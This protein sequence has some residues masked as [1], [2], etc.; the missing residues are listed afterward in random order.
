MIEQLRQR[1]YQLAVK[2]LFDQ[3]VLAEL[4]KTLTGAEQQ[5][6]QIPNYSLPANGEQIT[7]DM[8][9][10]VDLNQEQIAHIAAQVAGGMANIQDIYPLATLQEGILYHHRLQQE[11]D[12]YISPVILSFAT[13]QEV[14]SF[15]QALQK[16]IDRH[17]IL[18]TS[19]AW[20]SLEEPV[21]VVWRSAVLPVTQITIDAQALADGDVLN[22]LTRRANGDYA[23]LDVTQA[24]LMA[25]Y[26]TED[27]V[28]NRWLLCLINHH[29]NSDHTTMELLV[30]EVFAHMAGREA[31]LPTPLPFRDFVATSRFNA[32][33]EQ[34]QAFFT[35]QFADID[36]PC[37]PFDVLDLEENGAVDVSHL[38]LNAVLSQ[39]IR[40]MARKQGV[41]PAA[42]FHLAWG[43]VIKATSGRSD[44]VF[45][46]V[47]FGRMSA[48]QG[49]SR[50]LGMFLN[51]LPLKLTLSDVTLE[52]AL[53]D[54]HQ[55]LATL[56]DYEH[57]SLSLAQQ[58]S[59]LVGGAPLFS[60]L[61][62]YRYAGGSAQLDGIESSMDIVYSAEHSNYPVTLSVNDH[63]T[64]EF[65]LDLQIDQRLKSRG[66]D[67]MLV[68]ALEQISTQL[69]SGL[70]VPTHQLSVLP[71]AQYHQLVHQLN[72]TTRVVDQVS[73][74]HQLFERQVEMYPDQLAVVSA[75][76]QLT[77]AELNAQA[78]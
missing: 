2:A 22:E 41:S 68:A 21:Q 45:G 64:G 39:R 54:T 16:V 55:S 75:D 37:A 65:S 28:N 77:Y 73:C 58:C 47:L 51:T 72:Q 69:V 67:T 9:P 60:S 24:P 5:D 1:G 12:P 31:E 4:A 14:V 44:V 53:H 29:L 71:Q 23:H 10:L 52:S 19:M 17:D 6:W 61:M 34:H 36:E 20:E 70:D 27:S 38:G 78:N 59:G 40:A 50:V 35:E 13:E 63:I 32:N 46:T 42:M 26:H 15:T 66:I 43:L 3:P 74:V 76:R 49:A 25:A 57:A 8:L 48:G 7:P 18:R 62:N 33:S 56:L 30:E 11:R